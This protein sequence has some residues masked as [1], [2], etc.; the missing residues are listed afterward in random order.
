MRH[1]QYYSV[2]RR[3]R[4]RGKKSTVIKFMTI[5]GITIGFIITGFLIYNN[6]KLEDK[7]ILKDRIGNMY[8]SNIENTVDSFTKELAVI[9]DESIFNDSSF[10]AKALAIFDVNNKNVLYSNNGYE[11]IYPASMTKLMTAYMVLN[12]GNLGDMV[13]I[14]EDAMIKVSGTSLSG[15]RVGEILSMEQLLYALLLP[16]GNDAANAIAIHMSGSVEAF[17]EEMNE[18]AAFIGATKTNFTNPH[19]LHDDNHYTTVY[20][21]YLII[22]ELKDNEK[23]K[24]VI[25]TA[26]YTAEYEDAN[27]VSVTREWRSTNR[28]LIGE[29]NPPEGIIILGGKTG[30]TNE[31]GFCLSLIVH[32]PNG[33]EYISIISNAETRNL[34]YIQMGNLLSQILN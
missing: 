3:R 30:T 6:L 24:E 10:T 34:L 15:I 20:D 8:F 25:N 14:T 11:K 19:G 4:R 28:Y 5:T 22:N 12:Y 7:Y 21:I 9:E 31:A 29:A 18:K 27:G 26:R 13:T 2:R 16:S 32:E 33:N 23:F 1:N 17:C